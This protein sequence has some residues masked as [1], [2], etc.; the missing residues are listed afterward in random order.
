M[1]PVERKEKQKETNRLVAEEACM[2]GLKVLT[3]HK[4]NSMFGIKYNIRWVGESIEEGRC[5]R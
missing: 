1:Q 5:K 3:Q 4:K 2:I